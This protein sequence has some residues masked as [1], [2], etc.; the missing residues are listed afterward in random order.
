MGAIFLGLFAVGVIA[1]ATKKKTNPPAVSSGTAQLRKGKT[2]RIQLSV[3]GGLADD[4]NRRPD[5]ALAMQ[6][7][8]GMAGAYDIYVAP[9]FPML[10]EYSLVAEGDTPVVL[11]V[12]VQQ[13]IGG[14]AGEY[15]FTRIQEI[16][17]KKEPA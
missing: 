1:A 8:L 2:Y 14:L 4:P 7:G 6:N 17:R 5:A 11:N 9:T 16:A 12:P 15:T 3:R 13:V 10:V